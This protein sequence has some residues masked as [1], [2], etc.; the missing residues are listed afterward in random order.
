MKSASALVLCLMM[1]MPVSGLQAASQQPIGSA[2]VVV[3]LVTAAFNRDTRTLQ[4]GD[5][6]HQDEE[7]EV[8]LDASSELKLDDD[9]KLAL[10]PGARLM[11]DKFV[12]DPAKTKGSI[13]L[14]L[15]KGS[16]R[17]ITGVAEKPTYV[18][19]TPSAAITVRGTI[20]DVYVEDNGES[21]LLLL[22][23]AIQVCNA[24]G[25]CRDLTEPGK[26]I[27]ISEDGDVGPPSRW[28]S[29]SDKDGVPFDNAFPFV[30]QP[31]SIDPTPTLTRDVIILGAL[32]K[33]D[34]PKADPPTKRRTETT[35]PTKKRAERTPTKT[36]EKT[37]PKKKTRTA[38][39]RDSGDGN[40]VSGM[41]IVIGIGGGIG[42]GIGGGKHRGGNKHPSGGRGGSL[43]D[44][45]R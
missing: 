3:N 6:V 20:F 39:K 14:D 28:A 36:Q 43:T 18:I 9:T 8:G 22:E 1:L 42:R 5:R 7:I 26:L 17:F 25:Q 44:G 11:L 27:R 30:T 41:D 37:K 12:Y 23:G 13:V 40:I 10:G 29:L 24:R 16:F 19:K 2:L 15:V 35:K 38:K 31:P 45:G 21:W 4:N 32:P 33:T 34:P